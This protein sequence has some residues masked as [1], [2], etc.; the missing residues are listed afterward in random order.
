V[1][2]S[3]TDVGG[4]GGAKRNGPCHAVKWRTDGKEK[5]VQKATR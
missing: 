4:R 2:G 3:R 5:A 1:E